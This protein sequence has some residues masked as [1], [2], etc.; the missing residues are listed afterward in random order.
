LAA[1]LYPRLH[2]VRLGATRLPCPRLLNLS[3][4]REPVT[5]V[6]FQNGPDFLFH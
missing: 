6:L 1:D 3:E 5:N 2:F 4:Q